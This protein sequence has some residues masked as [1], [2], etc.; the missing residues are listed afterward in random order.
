MHV[1]RTGRTTYLSELQRG[2]CLGP[3]I[4]FERL[5][6]LVLSNDFGCGASGDRMDFLY[7]IRSFGAGMYDPE[8]QSS[9]VFEVKCSGRKLSMN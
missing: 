1:G 6:C 3:G 4:E 7:L 9:R 2:G 5:R 8:L